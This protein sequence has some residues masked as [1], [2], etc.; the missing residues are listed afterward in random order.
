[1][2][3]IQTHRCEQCGLLHA[4]EDG[5][6]TCRA[7]RRDGLPCTQFPVGGDFGTVCKMHGGSTKLNRKKV[8]ERRQMATIER[9][10]LKLVADWDPARRYPT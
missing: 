8:V 5:R 3:R 9:K 2:T 10:L 4:R 1:M 7:H 6:R